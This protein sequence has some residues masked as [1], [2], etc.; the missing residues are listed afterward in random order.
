MLLKA[1][2]LFLSSYYTQLF[3][4]I[5]CLD[6]QQIPCTT[7]NKIPVPGK[8]I[9]ILDLLFNILWDMEKG[10]HCMFFNLNDLNFVT[11]VGHILFQ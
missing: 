1:H 2:M 4:K 10:M 7:Y 9:K 3:K 8:K 11:T 6:C 5:I